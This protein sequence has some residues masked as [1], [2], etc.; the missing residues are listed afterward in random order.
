MAIY[1]NKEGTLRLY[2]NTSVTPYYL[3]VPFA[4]GDLSA[5]IGRP[6]AEERIILNNGAADSNAHMIEGPDDV[7]FQGL[8]ISFQALVHS[9]TTRGYL[10][11]WLNG[12]NDGA[13]T[14]VN[15]NTIVT[16]KGT[17]TVGGITAPAFSDSNKIACNV[18]L[19][20]DKGAN[21]WGIQ[22]AEVWF[23]LD[24][25]QLSNS[26]EAVA[27]ALSGL[28]FGAIDNGLTAFTTGGDITS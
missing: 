18:E 16:T 10:F 15:S 3:E 14:T 27:I 17:T 9:A 5:P 6:L 23:P 1:I 22:F 2:D 20:F 19:F 4:G 24:Q 21:D 26:E 13:T 7:I 25:C 28:I 8:P 12:M 11:D